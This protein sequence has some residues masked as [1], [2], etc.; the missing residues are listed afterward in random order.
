[1][2]YFSMVP[3]NEALNEAY[4]ILKDLKLLY[5]RGIGCDYQTVLLEAV[6]NAVQANDRN[7]G[8]RV[9]IGVFVSNIRLILMVGDEGGGFD[10]KLHLER[11]MPELFAT[12]GRGIPLIRH[13]G[14][15][16]KYR[17]RRGKGK[18]GMW[19]T[20]RWSRATA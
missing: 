9:V 12:S 13:L 5:P 3:T 10:P 11:P 15:E 17:Q 16:I 14:G 2:R 8:S 4:R 1:M 7:Q 6:A 19:L 20:V 18:A